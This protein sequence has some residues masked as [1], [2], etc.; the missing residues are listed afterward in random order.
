MLELA[1]FFAN[2]ASIVIVLGI[3]SGFI[4]RGENTPGFTFRLTVR[5]P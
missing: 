1:F 3:V 5:R 2:V 4:E